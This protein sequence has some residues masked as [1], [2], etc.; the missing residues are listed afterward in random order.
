MSVFFKETWGVCWEHFKIVFKKAQGSYRRVF[1]GVWNKQF[2]GSFWSVLSKF[3]GVS[4]IFQSCFKKVIRCL[5]KVFI[6]ASGKCQRCFEIVSH[7]I[8]K[9]YK[10]V[11]RV[12]FKVLKQ[13]NLRDFCQNLIG[14]FI[15][16]SSW[17]PKSTIQ[18]RKS[19]MISTS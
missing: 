10:G 8:Q 3:L 4:W 13:E 9:S 12:L 14:I 1:K 2:Q 7:L 18:D 11:W 16:V 5:R 15:M 6:V 17:K 19:W